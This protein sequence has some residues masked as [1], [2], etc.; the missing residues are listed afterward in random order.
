MAGKTS[1]TFSRAAPLSRPVDA[2]WRATG[3]AGS[4]ERP[5]KHKR[6]TRATQE[7]NTLYSRY[8]LACTRLWGSLVWP[9]PPSQGSMFEVRG[10]ELGV[11]H[12]PSEYDW[13]PAP[14]SGWS[15]GPLDKPWTCPGTIEH[16]KGSHFNQASL[17]KSRSCGFSALKRCPGLDVGCWMLDVRPTSPARMGLVSSLHCIPWAK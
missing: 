6:S 16:P 3:A 4:A 9:C 15:G 8:S 11:H 2:E 10:S 12:K 13:P 7:S 14:P 17:S 5:G 1:V